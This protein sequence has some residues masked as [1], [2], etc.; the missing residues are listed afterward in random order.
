MRRLCRNPADS[1]PDCKHPRFNDPGGIYRLNHNRGNDTRTDFH[2]LIDLRRH[3]AFR[4]IWRNSLYAGL[5]NTVIYHL[6]H[7]GTFLL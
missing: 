3:E 4:A 7:T 1:E 6:S 5:H 2:Q